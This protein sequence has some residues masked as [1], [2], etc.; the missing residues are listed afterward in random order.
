MALEIP[1]VVQ[2]ERPQ[3]EGNQFRFLINLVFG[4]WRIISLSMMAGA[5]IFCLIAFYLKRA[6][7]RTWTTYADLEVRQTPWDSEILRN[8]REVRVLPAS[9]EELVRAENEEAVAQDVVEALIERDLAEGGPYSILVT[10]EEVRDKAAEVME[11]LRIEAVPNSPFIRITAEGCASAAEAEDLAEFGA[12]VFLRRNRNLHLEEGREAHKF[13]KARLEQLQEQLS[14]AEIAEWKYKKEVGFR[15]YG[16]VGEELAKMERDM[17]EVNAMKESLTTKLAELNAELETNR[18]QFP[19][20]LGNVTDNVVDT[21][22]DDLDELLQEKLSMS[23]YRTPEHWE[24]VALEERIVEKQQAIL[25]A[26]Q[27]ADTGI[28]GGSDMWRRRKALREEEIKLRVQL[29]AQ[30]IRAQALRRQFEDM[31]P[32]IP[33]LA[34][35]KLQADKLAQETQRIRKEFDTLFEQEW[36][37][38]SILGRGTGQLERYRSVK[39]AA[40]VDFGMVGGRF[41]AALAIGLAAGGFISLMLVLMWEVNDTSIR[42]IEDVNQYLGLEVLGTIPQ[43]RFG[44]PRLGKRRRATYVTTVDEEQI[45]ACIVTQ[46]DPKSPVSEAYRT[47]RTNFQFA[48]LNLKPRTV[49]VTSAVPGEGKSTTAVNLAVTMAD[50]G[51]RVLIVDTDLRRPNVHRVLRMERGPGLA[52]LLREGLD[53][54]AVVRPTRVDNL[55]MIS[56][57]RVPPNPSELIGS[58]RMAEVMEQL[59]KDFDLV[60]CDAPSVL[61]VTDPVL[62]ATHV[63]TCIMVVTANFARRETIMRANKLLQTANVNIAGVVVNA[64]E[65]TRRNYYYYYYYYEDGGARTRKWYHL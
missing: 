46:H 54:H 38:R 50:R 12:R 27:Q 64:L 34:E 60:I 16:D 6:P 57:G 28:P 55:H 29:T 62:L 52:D 24:M 3:P 51:L 4:Y 42:S 33:D 13:I 9:A 22:I 59:G 39:A 36:E 44:K 48:T 40:F 32:R 25:E 47:L 63:D 17:A 20:S 65:T 1:K 45:D 61:V 53:I 31:V 8:L 18:K 7:E 35:K 41:W 5:L 30:E 37:L 2:T 49:M 11:K 10:K 43:M 15:A 26:E 56:S 14:R 19:E 23:T 21:L 58:D